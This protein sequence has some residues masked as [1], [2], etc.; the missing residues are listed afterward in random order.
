MKVRLFGAGVVLSLVASAGVLQAPAAAGAR[1]EPAP[2]LPLGPP[3]LS[4]TRTTTTLQPGVTLTRIVRGADAPA[5]PWTVEVAV[6][7]GETS[8]D[9]DAPPTALK[10]RASADELAGELRRDGF[11][12]RAEEVVTPAVAD[13]AGGALGWR[14]RV[15]SFAVRSAADAE[16]TRLTGAGHAGSTLYTGWDGEAGDRGPWRVDVLTVDPRRFRGSLD[17]SYGPDLERRERTSELAAAGG[18]FAAV[19]AGFFVLDPRAGAPGDPAGTGVYG[20]RVLSE[21]VAGRPALVTEADGGSRVVRTVWRGRLVGPDA[22]LALDGVNRVPGLV[23][24]CGGTAD[25]TPT[26][27]P[28]HDVTCQDPDELVA[29]TD[30]FGPRTPEG[31]GTEAVLDARGRVLEV[32]APRGGVLPEGGSTVQATGEQADR[33]ARLARVGERLRVEASLRDAQGRELPLSPSTS[34]VNGGPELVRDGRPYVT[35]AADGMVQ[36]GNPSFYYGWMHKRSPRT[37]AGTDDA[38]RTVLVTAEGRDTDALGLSIPESA[39]VARALGLRDAVN[40]DGGGSTTMVVHGDV[41]TDPSDAAGERPVGD[42]LLI[43][44]RRD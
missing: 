43:R 41:L 34:V 1:A 23:R 29:F 14:V 22:A 7:G 38:G 2:E 16:R 36:E 6:P 35:P 33:L 25:D 24:N 40:L 4:E 12:A 10:D 13:F 42:A 31:E 15:G 11:D 9:P 18:A 37:L 27:R 39:A 28:L 3:G 5:L 30:G 17:A 20:G 21:P 26:A 32:R 8:P 19:N 44:P